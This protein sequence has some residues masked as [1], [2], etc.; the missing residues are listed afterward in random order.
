LQRIAIARRR[1]VVIQRY[2]VIGLIRADVGV[3]CHLCSLRLQLLRPAH[4][5]DRGLT[6][7]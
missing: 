3:D 4:R 7:L 2:E 5:G 1:C 6:L